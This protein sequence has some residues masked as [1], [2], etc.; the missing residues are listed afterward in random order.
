MGGGI[1]GRRC[2]EGW[3]RRGAGWYRRGAEGIGGVV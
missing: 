1:G 3:Y 2:K